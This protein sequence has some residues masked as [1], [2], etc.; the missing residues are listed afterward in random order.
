MFDFIWTD[1]TWRCIFY[2]IELNANWSMGLRV[3]FH[4]FPFLFSR[5]CAFECWWCHLAKVV[6][7]FWSV[8]FM[9]YLFLCFVRFV[10]LKVWI[11]SESNAVEQQLQNQTKSDGKQKGFLFFNS[12]FSLCIC[13]CGCCC[14]N[15][16][17]LQERSIWL[18]YCTRWVEI[19]IFFIHWSKW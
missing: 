6:F 13:C 12:L 9:A 14:C 17:R 3:F 4:L 8:W 5:K 18:Q 2:L 10:N 19:L 7:S 16:E 15:A 11:E 1:G